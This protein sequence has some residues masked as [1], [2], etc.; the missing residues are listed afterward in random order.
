MDQTSKMSFFNPKVGLNYLLNNKTS[1]YAFAGVGNKEPSRDDFT[2]S[3]PNSRPSHES[4]ID[5]R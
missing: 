4:L 5:M 1:L 2:E 3:T